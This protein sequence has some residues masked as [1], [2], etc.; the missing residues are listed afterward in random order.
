M[1]F[2]YAPEDEAFRT[3][4]VAWLDEN[5]P[6][7]L[8]RGEIG[9]SDEEGLLRT[10]HRRQAWQRRL[11]EGRWAAINWPREW[12]GREATIMQNVVYSEEMARRK[13][14]GIYN[15]NGIWQIGPMIIKWGT[16]EQKRRWL[17]GILN[18][19]E[20]WC[21]G[22]SEPQAG[23]D[24]GNLRTSAI[25]DG[26]VYVLNGQKIWISTAHLAQWGLFLVRTDPSGLAE[27]RK[28][29]GITALIVDMR[30]AGIECRPIREITGEAMFNEVF[31]TDAPVP[32][33]YGLGEEGQGW[34]VAMGTL[35]H[36]RVGTA[37]I[38]IG[39][40]F[41]LDNMIAAARKHNPEALADPDIRDRIARAHT[42]I[43]FT[44]LLNARALT[45]VLK[46]EKTWPEVPIAKLQWS[47]LSQY[48]A[49]LY[50]DILGPAGLLAKGGPDAVDRGHAAYN[51]PWQ[52]YTSIGAGTTEVQKNII[53]D[54]A[55]QLPRK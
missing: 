32:V 8:A 6:N 21:Q 16:D 30:A 31:F 48:L 11:N 33:A 4:L 5:L 12:G 37:G 23:S 1:D 7:F 34:Q 40:K 13:T 3:E 39:L 19:D 46:G 49:E 36:E 41:E 29:E 24:L 44:R 22:F 55:I 52:R 2:S 53:A 47:F 50:V 25:R 35:G 14:P 20:H 42:Q 51:Y 26:D 38:S 10:M 15:A 28:H 27:G 17:P 18:A 45:K 9:D 43:E 54:R